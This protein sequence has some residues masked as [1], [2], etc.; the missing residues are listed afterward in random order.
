MYHVGAESKNI[1]VI[2]EA[3]D[4]QTDTFGESELLAAYSSFTVS[5]FT[6]Y[7]FVRF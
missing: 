6:F 5:Y 2:V 1:K 3:Q 4:W 7:P